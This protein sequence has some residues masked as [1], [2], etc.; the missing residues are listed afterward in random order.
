MSRRPVRVIL[1]RGKSK[2]FWV[3]HPWVF[4]GAIKRV[5]GDCPEDTGT[6]CVV[7]D[8][9]GNV[10]GSGFYNPNG[11]IAVRLFEHRRSTDISFE[12]TPFDKLV[13]QRLE[14]AVARRAALGLPNDTTDA[15]RLVNAEG[16]GLPGLI[17]DQLADVL[18][19]QLNSRAMYDM[20]DVVVAELDTC[21]PGCSTIVAAV[22]DTASRLESI[23]VSFEAVRGSLGPVTCRENGVRFE[24]DLQHSQKTGLFIDQRDNRR[25]FAQLC[26]S[27]TVLDVFCYVGG[28]GIGALVG[29]AHSVLAVD[30]SR[31]ACDA[32][33]RNAE[34]NSVADRFDI[35]CMDAMTAL[36]ELN[37]KRHAKF[38][39]VACDPPKFARGRSHIKDALKKYVRLNTL[40]LSVLADDGMLLSSSCSEHVSE[41]DF[42]RVL[43]EAGHR[44]RKNVVVHAMWGQAPDHPFSAVAPEGRYLKAALISLS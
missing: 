24:I 8:D 12:P 42:L 38:D 32:A 44:L 36:K 40:A 35:Q 37:G 15:V 18:I 26:A 11:H 16:D 41:K 43:N 4:S 5:D 14:R 3:G 19:L 6:A 22:T 13:R 30:S 28:F 27:K 17:V 29:G 20:R 1:K 25:R 33:R 7:E 34:L 10:L 2:P 31:A 23:P 9:L 39:R 21:R